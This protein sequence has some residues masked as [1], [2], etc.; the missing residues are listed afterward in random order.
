M[1]QARPSDPAAWANR[2]LW[3]LCFGVN[4]VGTTGSGDATLAGFLSTLLRDMPLQA[5]LTTAVA[6][7]ACNV[8]AADALSG[9]RP[10]EETLQRVAGGWP[11]RPLTLSAPGWR[12]DNS[13]QLWFSPYQ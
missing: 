1:G 9:I 13:A 11:Q 7:G 2:E 5:A 8:E 12:F 3:A 6:V 10:W 4:L